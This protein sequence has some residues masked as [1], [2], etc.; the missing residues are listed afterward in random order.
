MLGVYGMG[1]VESLKSFQIL[2]NLSPRELEFL[3]I[4]IWQQMM[5]LENSR[6]LFRKI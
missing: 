3:I 1:G 2:M 6:S 4:L 5:N